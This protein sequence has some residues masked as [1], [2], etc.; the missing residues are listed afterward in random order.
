MFDESKTRPERRWTR[1]ELAGLLAV[2]W[3]LAILLF[4]ILTAR[5]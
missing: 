3:F 5:P 2:I 4:F 1:V